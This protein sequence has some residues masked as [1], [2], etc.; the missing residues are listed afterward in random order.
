MYFADLVP[1]D[2]VPDTVDQTSANSWVTWF[3]GTPLRLLLTALI[4]ALVLVI[5]R[6][7]IKSTT[8]HLADGTWM[9]RPGLRELGATDMGAAL[10]RANPL[11]NA[12]R[13]Q[14]ART[15]GSVLRSTST[16]IIGSIVALMML[17]DVGMNITPLL[18][19]AGVVGVALGFGA[20]SLV[21]DFLS[22]MFLLMEDQYGVGDTIT[23]GD[24]SGTVE[25]VAL[26]ITKIRDEA[27]TLWF[28]RNGEILR[29]GNRTQ[30]WSRA[31]IDVAV[32]ADTDLAK[33]RAALVRAGERITGDPV[34]S[35]YLQED[36]EV[37]GIESLS[38]DSVLLKVQV[39][40]DPAMQWEVAR[41][42]REAVRLEL[43]AAGIALAA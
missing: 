24:V 14:R 36:P 37:V 21:R 3:L 18:A 20:Q 26:R 19:S 13:A 42:L 25:A 15:I 30:G 32:P 28:I 2:L 43:E 34:L 22:G 33:A 6:R 40:T 17:D 38:A 1:D 12:R 35:G 27:G 16:L 9:N 29:V 7:L 41:A 23:V 5:V 4:G 11:A 8:D 39:K 10:L 31:V